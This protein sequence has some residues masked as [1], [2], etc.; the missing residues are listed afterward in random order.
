MRLYAVEG[1]LPVGKSALQIGS[2]VLLM[3]VLDGTTAM[4]SLA[5]TYVRV[6]ANVCSPWLKSKRVTGL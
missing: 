3:R 6:Y 4:F 2:K 1:S 5:Q